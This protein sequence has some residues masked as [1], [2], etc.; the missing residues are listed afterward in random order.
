M[1]VHMK[2]AQ[3][4]A[5]PFNLHCSTAPNNSI[6]LRCPTLLLNSPDAFYTKNAIQTDLRPAH[7]NPSPSVSLLVLTLKP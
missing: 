6:L 1:T 7:C 4:Q 2:A 5:P 3:P